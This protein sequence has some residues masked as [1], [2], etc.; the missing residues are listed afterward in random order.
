MAPTSKDLSSLTRR[1]AMIA[2]SKGD[3]AAAP[4]VPSLHLEARNLPDRARVIGL[5]LEFRVAVV[6]IDDE[7][8]TLVAHRHVF[9]VALERENAP[10]LRKVLDREL[11]RVVVQRHDRDAPAR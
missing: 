10:V 1:S 9:A 4:P 11:A 5:A 7:Q 6:R 3:R 2:F 8:R